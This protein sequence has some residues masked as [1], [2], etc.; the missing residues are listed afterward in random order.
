MLKF[1]YNLLIDPLGLPLGLIE[2]YII[3]LIVEIIVHKIAF[4]ISPGG[5]F[6]S[7]IY[8][9]TKLLAFVAIWAALYA[10]IASVQF[11]IAWLS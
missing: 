7:L 8:W 2:E 10:V 6:G 4:R 9:V 3:L 1:F 11:V 5:T